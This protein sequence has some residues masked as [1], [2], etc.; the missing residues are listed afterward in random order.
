MP[1]NTRRKSVSLTLLGIHV[2]NS[3]RSSKAESHTA[4]PQAEGDEGEEQRPPKKLK[5]S[6]T[7]PEHPESPLSPP[8]S[9]PPKIQQERRRSAVRGAENTPPPSPGEAGGFRVDTEGI[10]DDIVVGVIEQLEKT[11]NRPHLLK[12]LAAVLQN[13]IP[14]VERYASREHHQYLEHRTN[15]N[16][17]SANQSAIISSRLST[18]LRRPWTALSPCPVGRE[19]IGTHPKRIYFYL[20]TQPRQPFPEPQ[21]TQSTTSRIISPSLTSAENEEEDEHIS[22]SRSEMSPSPEIDLSSPELEDG[23]SHM[24]ASSPFSGSHILSHTTSHETSRGSMAHGRTSPPLERDE[25]E[26]TQTASSLQRRRKSESLEIRAEDLPAPAL[27][28]IDEPMVDA[29]ESEERAAQRNEE[30]AAALFGHTNGTL[31]IPPASFMESSPMLRP[32]M[33]VDVTPSSKQHR[34]T[35]HDSH[36]VRWS[37]DMVESLLMCESVELDELDDLFQSY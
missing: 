26:F 5:R 13:T 18:Y 37:E 14:I 12:E 33:D 20:T 7:P 34:A 36:D 31:S 9:I 30:A 25:R 1:Y 23:Q 29:D 2:P 10:N 22:R 16:H 35:V 4:T 27:P 17:S 3:S 19:L 8:R 28:T 24:T 21:D 32:Q 15:Y 11:G 6:H